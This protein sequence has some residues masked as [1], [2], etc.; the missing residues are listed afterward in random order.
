MKTIKIG[1]IALGIMAVSF[2]S[3]KE[4]KTEAEQAIEEAKED[5]VEIKEKNTDDGYKLKTENLNGSETK[6]KVNEDGA[7]KIKTDY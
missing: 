7:V 2:S 1:A 3:C 6:V 5:A 4:K